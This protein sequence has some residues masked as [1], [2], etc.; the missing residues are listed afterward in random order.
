MIEQLRQDYILTARSKGQSEG[1]I[2]YRHALKNALIPIILTVGTMFGVSL[3]GVFIVEW[4][5]S[6]PGLGVYTLSSVM[7]RDST[8][9]QGITLYISIIYS[10]VILIIDIV[11]AFVNPHI[12]SQY[13]KKYHR[14]TLFKTK[15]TVLPVAVSNR[16]NR[17]LGLLVSSPW[18]PWFVP[19]VY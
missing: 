19:L 13:S 6:L 1:K 16:K 2:V 3:S 15:G 17:P 5:F 10:I 11:F 9:L 7:M 18:F 14:Q 4:I 8:S 12:R